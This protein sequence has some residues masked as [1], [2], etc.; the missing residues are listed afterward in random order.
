M[1]QSSLTEEIL[2][3]KIDEILAKEKAKFN[4]QNLTQ[5]CGPQKETHAQGILGELYF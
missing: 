1:L 4:G 5:I 3:S 2:R